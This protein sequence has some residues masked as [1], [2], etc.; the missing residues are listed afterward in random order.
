MRDGGRLA[1][2][3][4]VFALVAPGE[5]GDGRIGRG[6]RIDGRL[7][8][9]DA[10]DDVGGLPAGVV[11]GE[12]RVAMGAEADALGATEGARLDDEDLLAGGLHSNA[13]TGEFVVPE[14]GVRAVDRETVH[15]ALGE[16]AELAFGYGAAILRSASALPGFR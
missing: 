9:L 5:V 3:G 11:D 6:L 8:G 2:H 16:G 15:G 1:V 13:E 10:R 7:S 12:A 14:D 4:D